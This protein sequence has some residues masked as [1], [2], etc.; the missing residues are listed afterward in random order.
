MGH[1]AKRGK[2]WMRRECI[3]I[4]AN[5]CLAPMNESAFMFGKLKL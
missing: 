3:E 4:G 5:F 1:N 2:G